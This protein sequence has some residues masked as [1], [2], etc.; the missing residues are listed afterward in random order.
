MG[1]KNV[2]TKI[3]TEKSVF[4]I[5]ISDFVLLQMTHVLSLLI[6]KVKSTAFEILS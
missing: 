5:M 2:N 4:K 3:D 6:M 1:N